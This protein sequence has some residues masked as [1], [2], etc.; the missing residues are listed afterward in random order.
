MTRKVL[1]FV[2]TTKGLINLAFGAG[3]ALAPQALLSIYGVSLD[4]NGVL[5]ARLFGAA[6]LGI[7]AVQFLGRRIEDGPTKSL[8]IGAFAAADLLGLGIATVGQL[9]GS[10]NEL[11]WVVVGLYAFAG[12]GF[13]YG[14]AT[15]CL[16]QR[17]SA[18]A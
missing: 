11:G 3:I 2:L 16:P 12:L 14:F 13:A 17:R 1:P 10:M 8:L 9:Q 5:I 4:T 6:L 15:E 7:G 18:Q